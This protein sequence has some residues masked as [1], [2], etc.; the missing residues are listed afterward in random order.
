[1]NPIAWAASGLRSTM[2]AQA[3]AQVIA[4]ANSSDRPTAAS[5]SAGP[6]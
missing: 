5:A 2:P 4:N 3:P 1:M 6:L